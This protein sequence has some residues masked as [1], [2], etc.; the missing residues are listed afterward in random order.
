MDLLMSFLQDLRQAILDRDKLG[1]DNLQ[2]RQDF[3]G[4]RFDLV[5]S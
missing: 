4:Q 1:R 3:T 5:T 2:V